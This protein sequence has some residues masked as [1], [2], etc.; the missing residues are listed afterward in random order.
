[1]EK[2]FQILTAR[3]MEISQVKFDIEQLAYAKIYTALKQFN[4]YEIGGMLIGYQKGK[5]H[6][7]IADVTIADDTGKFS[8]FNFIREPIKSIKIVTELFKKKKYNYIGEWHSHPKF[9]LQ[10]SSKDI[11]TMK[12][13]ISDKGYGVNFVLLIITKLN[14][15]KADMSGFLFHNKLSRFIEAKLTNE[16]VK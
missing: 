15:G 14:D 4:H 5:N 8:I 9:T 2:Y 11:A 7:A 12:G 3:M 1:M 16:H 13:I 6:F 10:P